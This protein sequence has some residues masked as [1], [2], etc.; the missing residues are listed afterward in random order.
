M[1]SKRHRQQLIK[2][3]VRQQRLGTQQGLVKALGSVGCD[4]TQ[5]TISRDI[6]E[7]GLQKSRDE[8]G[9]PTYAL[10]EGD[11]RRDPQAMCA[12]MLAEFGYEVLEA[13]HMVLVKS[14][15]GTASGLGKVIDELGDERILGTVAGDDT[16]MIVTR[17][18][19]QARNVGEYLRRLGG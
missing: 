12:R 9:R 7:L 15:P 5:A 11:E 6:H 19:E 2:T 1:L 3:L 18:N 17:D 14:E 4:V 13:Q 8:L 10:P 16:L